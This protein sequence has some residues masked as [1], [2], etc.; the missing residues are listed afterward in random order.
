MKFFK[1]TDIIIIV[2]ILAV[3]LASWLTYSH[4]SSGRSVLAEIYYRSELVKTVDLSR[5]KEEVFS[6]PQ[7][8]NVIFHVFPDGRIQFE[9]SDCPDKVCVN[10]G[11]LGTAGQFAACLPNE[12]VM[13]IVPKNG[14]NEDD[15][16]MVIGN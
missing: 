10:A 15:I 12:I 6:I 11:K 2:C 5:G 16:D 7:D 9:A 1:K 13:K 8:R 3:G 4:F 14:S